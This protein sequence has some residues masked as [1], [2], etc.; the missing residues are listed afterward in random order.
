MPFNKLRI[1][2]ALERIVARLERNQ[3]LS[4]ILV[5]KGGFVLL[6]EFGHGRFT[7]DLDMLVQA[8]SPEKI[9]NQMKE[10]LN[11]NLND[12]FWFGE[13]ETK[14]IKTREPVSGYRLTMAF[15]IGQ[16]KEKQ[17]KRLSRISLDLSFGDPLPFG[18][19]RE[20]MTS[21]IEG[22]E[23][24]SWS[25]YPIESIVSDK[26]EA[27]ISRGGISSRAK[28]IFDLSLLLHRCNDF[29]RLKKAIAETFN[30]YNTPV[31]TSFFE[32]VKNFDQT[33]LKAAWKNVETTTEVP[34]FDEAWSIVM[35]ELKRLDAG[36]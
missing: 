1:I 36:F 19:E 6:K 17:R 31:P 23:P 35:A 4:K 21:I 22:S 28:D 13:F 8:S 20:E 15:H 25:I 29:T 3:T 2:L 27:L 18:F 12:G 5:F 14:T 32:V 26:L 9:L 30:H 16:P 33:A 7:Q 10:A 34:T 24:V 11:E